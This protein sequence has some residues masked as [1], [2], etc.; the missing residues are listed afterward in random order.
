MTTST[1]TGLSAG[2]LIKSLLGGIAVGILSIGLLYLSQR[3]GW[4]PGNGSP[5]QQVLVWCH[6]NLKGS[7]G[8]FVLVLVVFLVLVDRLSYQLKSCSPLEQI[9]QT[10]YLAD[11]CTSLFFGIGVIWTAIGMR[12]ALLA[13][14]GNLDDSAAAAEVGAFQILK[15]LVD[16]GILLALS[17]TIVGGVGGYLM[18]IFKSMRTGAALRQRYVSESHASEQAVLKRLDTLNETML[19]MNR[20]VELPVSSE[21]SNERAD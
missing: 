14:L 1:Q 21:Y 9:S 7:I 11:L 2:S 6:E 3:A 13:G 15:N 10:D 16:G 19:A 18:R 17:T 5:L 12:S 4:L 20:Y 8:P